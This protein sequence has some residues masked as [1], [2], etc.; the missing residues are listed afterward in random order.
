M[1]ELESEL[2]GEDDVLRGKRRAIL[3]GHVLTELIRDSHL[4]VGQE[5]D[6][7]VIQGWHLLSQPPDGLARSPK[8]PRC[9]A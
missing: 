3:P 8:S 5:G 2:V 9:W 4:A 6:G 7:A 1:N